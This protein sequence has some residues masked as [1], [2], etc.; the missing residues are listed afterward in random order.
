MLVHVALLP[1]AWVALVLDLSSGTWGGAAACPVFLYLVAG[2]AAW[3]LSPGAAALW[4]AALGLLAD[5]VS[6]GPLG[7]EFL[8]VGTVSWL[9]ASFRRHGSLESALAFTL[10][11][12]LMTATLTACVALAQTFLHHQ[13]WDLRAIGLRSTAQAAAT[14][15]LGF[16]CLLIARA[17]QE[18]GARN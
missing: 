8:L 7:I 18:L 4:G 15:L 10:L 16:A 17:S 2:I 3:N 11:L 9:A 1:L 6:P 12:I 13:A 14:G 5:A